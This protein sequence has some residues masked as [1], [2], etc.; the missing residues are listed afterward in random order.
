MPPSDELAVEREA[1]AIAWAVWDRE[2]TGFG[3]FMNMMWAERILVGAKRRKICTITV[4]MVR[5]L[6]STQEG[7][8]H[9]TGVPLVKEIRSPWTVSLNRLDVKKG[10]VE[11][12]VVLCGGSNQ[13]G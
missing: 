12:N 10:Y 7:K 1:M 9:W 8:C 11:G 2:V 6:W 13:F 4:E 3:Y 5:A